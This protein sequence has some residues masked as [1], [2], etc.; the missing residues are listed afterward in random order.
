MANLFTTDSSIVGCGMCPLV[1]MNVVFTE[2][3]FYQVTN[4][5]ADILTCSLRR[6]RSESHFSTDNFQRS[7]SVSIS[8]IKMPVMA[9]STACPSNEWSSLNVNVYNNMERKLCIPV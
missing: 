6:G 2:P 9:V 1:E 8:V 4:G 5:G 3:P 7:V